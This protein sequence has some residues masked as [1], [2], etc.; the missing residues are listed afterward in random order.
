MHNRYDCVLF[1]LQDL[2]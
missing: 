1:N 2:S